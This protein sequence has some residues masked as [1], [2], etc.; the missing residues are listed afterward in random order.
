MQQIFDWFNNQINVLTLYLQV[1]SIGMYGL[2]VT[3]LI[4]A[5]VFMGLAL[6]LVA[7]KSPRLWTRVAA[8]V[9]LLPA[10]VLSMFIALSD[11]LG[12]PKPLPLSWLTTQGEKKFIEA[13]EW[14][15]KS[16]D[17]F[18]ER[19]GSTVLYSLPWTE[20]LSKQLQQ[21]RKDRAKHKG[22]GEMKIGGRKRFQPSLE[23]EEPPE[24]YFDPWEAPE[25]K[26]GDAPSKEEKPAEPKGPGRDA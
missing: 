13:K 3:K 14:H 19:E 5:S 18:V 16:I 25:P 12:R 8:V 26:D 22:R 17:L 11:Q 24:I 6:A 7:V 9:V 15:R 1:E 4:V 21:T 20:Q 23:T 2:S 10:L